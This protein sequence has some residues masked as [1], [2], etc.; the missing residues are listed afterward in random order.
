MCL[1]TFN[2]IGLSGQF[3]ILICCIIFCVGW[4][5]VAHPQGTCKETRKSVCK[6]LPTKGK[7]NKK[8][9]KNHKKSSFHT[10]TMTVIF[11]I[12]VSV[13]LPFLS[14]CSVEWMDMSPVEKKVLMY[15]QKIEI[16]NVKFLFY[17]N[18]ACTLEQRPILY[19]AIDDM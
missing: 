11:R 18:L 7:I 2:K 1:L 16:N 10:Q 3:C 12:I 17:S 19:Y 9:K 13:I 8:R 14:C 4:V 6:V 5:V 15:S